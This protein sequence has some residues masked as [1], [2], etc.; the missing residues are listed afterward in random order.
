[1]RC[2]EC[3][4]SKMK[5]QVLDNKEIV[6]ERHCYFNIPRTELIPN[7]RSLAQITFRPKVEDDDFCSEFSLKRVT[8]KEKDDLFAARIPSASSNIITDPS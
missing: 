6:S 8:D 4:Y 1:M 3:K 5:T 7:G 2:D